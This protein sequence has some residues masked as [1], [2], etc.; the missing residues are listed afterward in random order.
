MEVT[1]RPRVKICCIGS[2]E[3]ALIAIRH[4]A[5]AVGLVSAMPSGPG[6]IP[7]DQIAAIAANLPPAVG[8]FLL[9]CKQNAA[10]IIDQQ[11]RVRVNTIQICDSMGPGEYQTLREELPGLSIVQVIHVNGPD[12]VDEATSV[13]PF[14]NGILLDSGNQKLP[15][16]ELGGTGRTHDWTISARI[17]EA[18][19]VPVFLA[20][21]LSFANV[22]EAL[23]KVGPF[24]V[25]VCT[26]VRTEGKLD[27][28]KLSAFFAAIGRGRDL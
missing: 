24:G 16:K 10:A 6:P 21:G 9:T 22:A 26:G 23:I 3:E 14:V 17:R 28:E 19:Q 8:S 12:V 15:V 27:E 7:E 13:A 18:V 2:L 4:G 25:D 20:G 11:R 5:D 1:S